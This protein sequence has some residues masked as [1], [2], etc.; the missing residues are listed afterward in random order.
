MMQLW[1]KGNTG[2]SESVCD[3]GMGVGGC[4]RSE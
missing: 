3:G 1:K 2:L 4:D